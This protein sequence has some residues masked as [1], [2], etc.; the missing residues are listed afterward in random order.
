MQLP[1]ASASA[2]QRPANRT[3]WTQSDAGQ[4][5]AGDR[6]LNT[7]ARHVMHLDPDR[8]S[9]S[10]YDGSGNVMGTAPRGMFGY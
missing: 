3:D 7:M 8:Q 10:N 2:G 5:L 9:A 4:P 6:D 1:F